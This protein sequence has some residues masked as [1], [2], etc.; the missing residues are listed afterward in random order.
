[1]AG[2]FKLRTATNQAVGIDGIITMFVRIG[3][4]R[5]RAWFAVVHNVGVDKHLGTSFIDNCTRNI[6]W[7]NQKKVSLH[8]R[9]ESIQ[10][11]L[12]KVR[13]IF[14]DTFVLNTESAYVANWNDVDNDKR[15]EQ[16]HHLG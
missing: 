3:D 10:P 12:R 1:M 11:S 4:Y 16:F 2:P 5:V 7:S 15:K 13:L 9:P 8:S 14:L 6:F